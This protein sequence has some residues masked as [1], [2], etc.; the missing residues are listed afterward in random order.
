MVSG[1]DAYWYGQALRYSSTTAR[2]QDAACVRLGLLNA[3]TCQS[4][5]ALI[6][7]AQDGILPAT[8][9]IR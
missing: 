2:H 5:G 1:R 4:S 8:V 7:R 3:S 6:R 9:E